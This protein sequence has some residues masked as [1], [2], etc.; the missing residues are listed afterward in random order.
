MQLSKNILLFIAILCLS[1]PSFSQWNTKYDL[2]GDEIVDITDFSQLALHWL[3]TPYLEM[4]AVFGLEQNEAEN[5]LLSAGLR[6][7]S[8]SLQHSLSFPDGTVISQYP[9]AG[10][11]VASGDSVA[12]TV[13][14]RNQNRV[15]GMHWVFISDPNFTGYMSK[16]ETTN[17]QY[18]D[19]LN[20]AYAQGAVEILEEQVYAAG[21]GYSGRIYYDMSGSN[22]QITFSSGYFYVPGR[23]GFDMGDHPVTEVSWYGAKAFC[24]FYGFSLPTKDQ[25]EGVGDYQGS[26][27]FGCGE[28]ISYSKANYSRTNPL[29]LSDYPYTTPAGYYPAFGYGLCDMAGNVWEWTQSVCGDG[30]QIAVGGGWFSYDRESCSVSNTYC[31][32]PENTV[33]DTGF[34][35]LKQD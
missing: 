5:L 24:D 25:W 34:R 18:C 6:I 12:L 9:L 11:T 17:S 16:Y 29:G 3:E 27:N 32:R 15:S 19:F 10:R 26:F 2:N 4:P 20:E 23:E 1:V 28:E 33:S 13:S 22:A 30:G 35:V 7:G 31:D 21:G 8:L 14:T